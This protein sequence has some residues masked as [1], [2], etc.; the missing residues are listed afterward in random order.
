L[1]EEL[2]GSKLHVVVTADW[3]VSFA[4]S[5]AARQRDSARWIILYSVHG[6]FRI[7][8]MVK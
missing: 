6:V 4:A 3:R 1:A 7:K 5:G 2:E 8:C